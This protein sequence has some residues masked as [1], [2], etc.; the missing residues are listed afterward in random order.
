MPF[1]EIKNIG[2]PILSLLKKIFL[3]GGGRNENRVMD[4]IWYGIAYTICL[5]FSQVKIFD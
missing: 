1:T 5:S 4:G 3:G 2:F